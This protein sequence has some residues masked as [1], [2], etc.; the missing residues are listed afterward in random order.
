MVR[1]FT[2]NNHSDYLVSH[3]RGEDQLQSLPIKRDMLLIESGA[4]AERKCKED[5]LL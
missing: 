2:L 4:V 1:S 5:V 3:Y